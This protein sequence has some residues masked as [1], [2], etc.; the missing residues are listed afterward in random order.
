VFEV[1]VQEEPPEPSE[2]SEIFRIGMEALEYCG[3]FRS[4]RDQA[5]RARGHIISRRSSAVVVS[6]RLGPRSAPSGNRRTGQDLRFAALELPPL[7][8]MKRKSIRK[9]GTPGGAG[10]SREDEAISRHGRAGEPRRAGDPRP[11]RPPRLLGLVDDDAPGGDRLRVG[12]VD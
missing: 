1:F 10:A 4:S 2:S 12:D 5:S 3:S 8:F 6:L 11:T 9:E 7:R